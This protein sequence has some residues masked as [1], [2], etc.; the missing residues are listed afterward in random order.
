MM[1]SSP[2]CLDGVCR[3]GVGRAP[4]R[5]G[6]GPPLSPPLSPAVQTCSFFP[7]L[8]QKET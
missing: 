3:Q 6:L 2:G 4:R 7:L 8:C 5:R 1:G